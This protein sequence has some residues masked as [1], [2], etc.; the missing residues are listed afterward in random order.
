[1]NDKFDEQSERLYRR[2]QLEQ[3]KLK[4]QYF[5][6]KLLRFLKLDKCFKNKF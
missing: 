3:R 2:I 1:M 5:K 4:I 6:I